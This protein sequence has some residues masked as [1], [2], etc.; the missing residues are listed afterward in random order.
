MIQT[1][2]DRNKTDRNKYKLDWYI[3]AVLY[4]TYENVKK[5]LRSISYDP[6]G[7]SEDDMEDFMY[8]MRLPYA[9]Y[10]FMSMLLAG[11]YSFLDSQ[12]GRKP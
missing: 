6:N 11:D 10:T 9:K 8:K 4:P 1:E 2:M 12:D 7:V 3:L 5:G